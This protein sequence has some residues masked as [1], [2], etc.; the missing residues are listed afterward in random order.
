MIQRIK[1]LRE[2]ELVKG[3]FVLFFLIVVYNLFNYVFQISMAKM[4]GPEDYGIMAALMSIIYI[5]SI[6][7]EA[8][9]TM[10]T[11]Y[12]SVLIPSNGHGKVKDLLIRV[13]KKSLIFATLIFIIYVIISVLFLSEFLDISLDLMIFTG[14]F[15][16]VVFSLPAIRGVIQGMKRFSTLGFNLITEACIKVVLSLFLVFIG[17]K[18]F[19][20]IAAVLLASILTFFISLRVIKPIL[21][22]KRETQL[23]KNRYLGN[24]PILIATTAVVL[25]YSLDIIL[26]RRFFSS[27]IAGQFA[28]VSLIGKV[29]IFVGSSIGK[30]MFPISSEQFSKGNNT[31]KLL[32]KSLLMVSAFS[33]ASLL[34][35]YL[36]PGEIIRLISLVSDQ[37][38]GASNI[39]FILGASYSL[40]SISY[41]IILYRL[42]INVNRF[43]YSILIFVLIQ[44]ILLLVFNSNLLEYSLAILF[45]NFLLFIYSVLMLRNAQ[46]N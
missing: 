41:L 2:D 9:Q 18:V 16:F 40:L 15:I 32:I 10:I 45:S 39:L 21:A 24:L 11:K 17:W 23:F 33:L 5:F 38:I 46:K 8:V 44:L 3:S 27:T 43:V 19:G 12:T 14:L 37:Y 22:S 25:M 42:S 36:V 35:Y 30:T 6:P 7:S 26:A 4:L 28:F 1:N 34:L 13:L 31:K 29:I 20:S